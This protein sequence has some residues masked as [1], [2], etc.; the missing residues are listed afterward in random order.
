ME[1]EFIER[2]CRFSFSAI[3]SRH[4]TQESPEFRLESVV[5]SDEIR[6]QMRREDQTWGRGSGPV[7]KERSAGVGVPQCV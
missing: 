4:G 1:L 2:L 3:R 6:R 5:K 7:G